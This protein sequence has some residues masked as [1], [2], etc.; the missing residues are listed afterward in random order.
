MLGSSGV[1]DPSS[2]GGEH[3]GLIPRLCRDLFARADALASSPPSPNGERIAVSVTASF[4]EVYCEAVRDLLATQDA[5]ATS[6]LQTELS[7]R[8]SQAVTPAS[9][10]AAARRRKGGASPATI[11]PPS[12]TSASSSVSPVSSTSSASSTSPRVREHPVRGPYVEGLTEVPIA[13][14]R[15]AEQLL[16][17][18]TY[19]RRVGATR[20]NEASSRSHAVFT[21]ALCVTRMDVDTGLPV[22]E[23]TSKIVLVDL[24]GKSILSGVDARHILDSFRGL[25][26]GAS[27]CQ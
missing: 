19:H 3:L 5:P 9:T 6:P 13:S 11:S 4:F 16:V 22:D 17:A 24:A 12:S 14:Y 21:L 1:L 7:H 15:E 18:G 27:T 10:S 8:T 20:G 23:S 26:V 25:G 2:G